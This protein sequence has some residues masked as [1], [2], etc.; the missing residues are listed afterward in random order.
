M[1]GWGFFDSDSAKRATHTPAPVRIT[2]GRRRWAEMERDGSTQGAPKKVGGGLFRQSEVGSEWRDVR[3][4]RIVP[5]LKV[6]QLW[7]TLSGPLLVATCL[8]F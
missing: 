3:M 5:I 1:S 6:R 4:G 2:L 8:N 7:A